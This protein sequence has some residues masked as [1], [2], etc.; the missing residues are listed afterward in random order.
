MLYIVKY[1]IYN[2]GICCI[3][4]NYITA[5][6][7]KWEVSNIEWDANSVTEKK[8]LWTLRYKTEVYMCINA[9]VL[10]ISSAVGCTR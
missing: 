9:A 7:W 10:V 8:Y 1:L 3:V 5:W 2:E 6:D 4:T